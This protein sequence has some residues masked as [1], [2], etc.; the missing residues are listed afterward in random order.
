MAKLRLRA[1]FKANIFESQKSQCQVWV[2][3]KELPLKPGLLG[4]KSQECFYNLSN[5]NSKLTKLKY[6][7]FENKKFWWI[8]NSGS[9]QPF[10]CSDRTVAKKKMKSCSVWWWD[11]LV[12][13]LSHNLWFINCWYFKCLYIND[14]YAAYRL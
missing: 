12:I 7:T 9:L 13:Y 2:F 6:R 5:L 10:Q 3:I 14:L 1:K 11:T 4:G 8:K